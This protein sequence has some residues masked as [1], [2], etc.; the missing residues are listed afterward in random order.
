MGIVES[1]TV[2][3]KVTAQEAAKIA[4]DYYREVANDYDQPSTEEVEISEDQKYW[5]ITLGIRKQGGD[6][7]SSLYG[8]T[9][10]AY[11]IFKI[12]SQ[13]GDVLSMKIREV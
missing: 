13:T 12:D 7:I 9:Y 4:A 5:L 11:K 6:A 3:I 8:K 2:K 10:I 1:K